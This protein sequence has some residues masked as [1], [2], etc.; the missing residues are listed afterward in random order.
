MP[1]NISNEELNVYEDLLLLFILTANG[2]NPVA[3]VIQ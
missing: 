1:V 2:F 3:V